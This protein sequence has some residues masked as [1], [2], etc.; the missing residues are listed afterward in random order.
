[1][2]RDFGCP[3]EA[4]VRLPIAPGKL[5]AFDLANRDRTVVAECKAVGW[6]RA[7]NVP[8]AKITHLRE[9]ARYLRDL[10]GQLTRCLVISKSCHPSKKESLASYFVRLNGACLEGITVFELADDSDELVGL[11]DQKQETGT[12]ETGSRVL[13]VDDPGKIRRS[14]LYILDLAEGRRTSYEG[15]APRVARL[16]NEGKIP[17][18]IANGM[19][20]IFGYRDAAEYDRYVPTAADSGII[21]QT[22]A[23]VSQWARDNG[24]QFTEPEL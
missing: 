21:L 8:A 7:G 18:N 10:E 11:H 13:T 14:L 9:T 3:F 20:S 24:L 12:Q 16:R 5:H 17:R 15:P 22:W 2:E 6:T 19:L 1:L 23:I 4:E